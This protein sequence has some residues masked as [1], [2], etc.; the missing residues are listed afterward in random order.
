MLIKLI[1]TAVLCVGHAQAQDYEREKRWADEFEPS[2]VVGDA[3]RIRASSGRDFV[4]LYTEAK[5]PKPAIVLAHGVGVHPEFGVIG[6]LRAKLA[7][8]GYTTL[9]IQMP[10]QGKD[11]TVDDY[12]PK[13]FP[14][15]ADRLSKAAGWLMA[16]GH[17]N[18]VL[19]SHS[20]GAW[21]ANEYLDRAHESTP[22]KAWI[23]MGLT[24]SYSWGMRRYRF[25]ILD[26]HGEKDIAPVMGAT[27]RRKSALRESNGSRQVKIAGA[28]HHYTGRENDLAAAIDAF[29]RER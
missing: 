21:M 2:V 12:Y 19:L 17:Q 23:V 16:K 9:A 3:V 20:M 22:Y 18:V 26:V 1:L 27:A 14:D 15:A 7:D 25:P 5:G 6:L 13:V 28:D 11:A 8:M 24:G 29:L 4:A 10:V